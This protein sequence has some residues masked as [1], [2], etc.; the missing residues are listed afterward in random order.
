MLYVRVQAIGGTGGAVLS[1]KVCHDAVRPGQL[2]LL[3]Q[4]RA[5]NE[6]LAAELAE[7]PRKMQQENSARCELLKQAD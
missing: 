4:F 1:F 2:V 7:L 3:P 5:F 6:F